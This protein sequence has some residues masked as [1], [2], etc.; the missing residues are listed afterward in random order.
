[1]R[2]LI[3]LTSRSF[4]E[5]LVDIRFLLDKEV[6]D[7]QER[8][9][10]LEEAAQSGDAA[11]WE[12]VKSSFT[13]NPV[14]GLPHVASQLMSDFSSEKSNFKLAMGSDSNAEDDA[15]QWIATVPASED[16]FAKLLMC[17]LLCKGGLKQAPSLEKV[18]PEKDLEAQKC[19]KNKETEIEEEEEEEYE[20]GLQWEERSN[21][22]DHLSA[23]EMAARL[24]IGSVVGRGRD[25]QGTDSSM[26]SGKVKNIEAGK[27]TV[28]WSC[29]VRGTYNMGAEGQYCLKLFANH[30]ENGWGVLSR[31]TPESLNCDK[32]S[33]SNDIKEKTSLLTSGRLKNVRALLSLR[34]TSPGW[35]RQ[36]LQQA[37]ADLEDLVLV[38]PEQQHLDV[39]QDMPRLRKLVLM[40]AGK[41]VAPLP[42]GLEELYLQTVNRDQLLV[43]AKLP[44]LRRLEVG[45][46]F[47]DPVPEVPFPR[48][49][50]PAGLRWL[51]CGLY[52]LR[53]A[54]RLMRAHR[55]T[56]EVVEL[57][58]AS[59]EPYGCPDLATE[60]GRCRL[61][62]LKR[63]IF[64]R[65]TGKKFCKH[66]ALDCSKQK[67]QVWDVLMTL[68]ILTVVECSLCD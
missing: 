7:L 63:L 36:V 52:P 65:E 23:E 5:E 39:V 13:V 34:C 57:V 26:R 2:S 35:S 58:A 29:G 54:L 49:L 12:E 24:R 20:E 41:L 8:R 17:R 60:L 59:R 18:Q 37:A 6:T 38:N 55:A 32:L 4:E 25:W 68:G 47:S 15:V 51:R 19:E 30:L 33:G 21:T 64:L 28:Q 9:S 43:V 11:A 16:P 42:P 27:V 56:L 53:T 40:G 44:A 14:A 31:G 50:P 62:R 48:A 22:L 61:R 66:D 1:M 45:C 3:E 10:L 46:H 67:F